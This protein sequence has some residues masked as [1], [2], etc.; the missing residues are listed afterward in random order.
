MSGRDC[1]QIIMKGKKTCFVLFF[2]VVEE[3]EDRLYGFVRFG[4]QNDQREALIHMNGF[5]GLGEKR[6]KVVFF[7]YSL[8][9]APHPTH[10][11]N[12]SFD[13]S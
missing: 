11:R 7:Y 12:C 5:R 2:L 13:L 8:F 1:L 3:G 10:Q 9:L 6:I 4:D